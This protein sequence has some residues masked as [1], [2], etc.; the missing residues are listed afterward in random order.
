MLGEKSQI[1]FRVI[2][3][4]VFIGAGVKYLMGNEYL[5]AAITLTAGVVFTVF[6]IIKRNRK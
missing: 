4:I 1:V 5:P 2:A 6:I 3:A